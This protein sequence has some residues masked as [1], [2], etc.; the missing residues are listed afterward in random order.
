MII[1][2]LLFVGVFVIFVLSNG[3]TSEK[4]TIKNYYSDKY[5]TKEHLKKTLKSYY[6]HS[7][8]NEPLIKSMKGSELEPQITFNLIAN[9]Y[10]A[11]LKNIT[12]EANKLGLTVSEV[13]KTV[14]QVHNEILDIYIGNAKDFHV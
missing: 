1:F 6:I 11:L 4:V 10:K 2:A 8:E 5:H 7:I 14:K 3:F 13:E 9:I 12:T